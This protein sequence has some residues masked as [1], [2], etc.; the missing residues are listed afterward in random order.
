MSDL[1]C[2]VTGNPVGTDT[3]EASYECPCAGCQE[4]LSELKASGAWPPKPSF[5][6]GGWGYSGPLAQIPGKQPGPE[7]ARL[8]DRLFN[9]PTK[10]LRN[11]HVSWGPGAHK[12]TREQRA[13]AINDMLDAPSTRLDFVDSNRLPPIPPRQ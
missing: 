11:F 13:K 7:E 10:V 12:A 2:S 1:R 3:W 9:D 4:W 5:I 8:I 6:L